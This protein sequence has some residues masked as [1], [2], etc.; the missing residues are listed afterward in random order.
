MDDTIERGTAAAPTPPHPAPDTPA[1]L[2]GLLAFGL[3]GGV[4]SARGVRGVCLRWKGE[5]RPSPSARWIPFSAEETIEAQR[6]AFLWVARLSVGRAST[7]TVT[8]GYQDG[9]GWAGT[10][11]DAEAPAAH[12]TG[13][14]FD[15]G[16]LQ[17]YLGE[18]V[19]CPPILLAHSSL[20]WTAVG[21]STLRVRDGADPTGAVVEIELDATG[22]PLACRAARPRLVGKR[23]VVTPWS[24]EYGSSK[25]W[26]G[27]RVPSRLEASWIL[28]QGAFTY[29]REEVVSLVALR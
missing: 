2:A 17:R 20:I 27:L 18:I 5:L 26:D 21:P 10:G 6:S 25:L 23:S 29:V 22:A 16:E 28:P 14:D 7:L 8:D 4:T 12:A 24:G 19:L 15:R 1:L 3:P 9:H 13:P 11:I